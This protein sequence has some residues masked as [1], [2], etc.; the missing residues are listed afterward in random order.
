M[1]RYRKSIPY[2]EGPV[3]SLG[4]RGRPHRKVIH[5][6]KRVAPVAPAVEVEEEA[7]PPVAEPAVVEQHG[8]IEQHEQHEDI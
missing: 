1:A 8:V 3:V 2:S 4:S 5:F 6:T 7:T